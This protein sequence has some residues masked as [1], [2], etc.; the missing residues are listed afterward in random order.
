MPYQNIID[1][2]NNYKIKKSN[3]LNKII[4]LKPLE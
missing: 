4:Y 3:I 1:D 2:K